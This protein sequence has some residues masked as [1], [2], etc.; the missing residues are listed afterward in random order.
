MTNNIQERLATLAEFAITRS[1]HSRE[2]GDNKHHC[3]ECGILFTKTKF[4]RWYCGDECTYI[5]TQRILNQ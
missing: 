4:K 5:A 1:R 2:N 3:E